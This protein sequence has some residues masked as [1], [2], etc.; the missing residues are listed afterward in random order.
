[1]QSKSQRIVANRCIRISV[2]LALA[3]VVPL[4]SQAAAAEPEELSLP[5][6]LEKALA[7]NKQLAAFEYRLA[8][9]AGRQQQ[10]GLLPNPRLDL[11]VENFAG[12]GDFSGVD[13]AETTLSL[14]WAVEPGLRS[15]RAGIEEARSARVDLDAH[16]LQ[17]DVAAETAQRF[18]SSLESQAHLRATEQALVLAEQT[19]EVVER[20]VRAGRAPAAERLRALASLA[21][22]R[23]ARDDVTH[24]QSV[25]YHRLAAQWGETSPSFGS[26][27]GA[28]LDLPSVAP[29]AE[30]EARVES[31]PSLARLAS[32]QRVAA[33]Q[34]RL[35][36]AR[37]WPTATPSLGVR[38]LE[39]T[40]DWAMVAGVSVPLQ[41]F[42]RNQGRVAE[43]R[44]R[45]ARTRADAESEL[46][47]VRTRLYA[48][49][50][51]MQHS[52]HR[53]EVL[54]DEVI[55]RIEATLDE[56]E[57]G[58]ERGRYPYSDLRAVQ[59][60]LRVAR[61]SLVEASTAAHRLVITLERLTGER[62]AK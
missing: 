49:Y 35:A 8:E 4:C 39:I 57:K 1:M 24:E 36:E 38:R 60:E 62:V 22:E 37:R 28:L 13:G 56:L 2:T 7:H 55:P 53:T 25:A 41:L 43:S 14:G 50:Q 33:A 48:I 10:A 19:V 18:L 45:L 58:Y 15:R 54:Q 11:I 46:V 5:R 52:V 21:M 34:L 12:Q 31:N 59:A 42:D 47:L 51:E 23:L 29:F 32:E 30:L 9:Q 3:S 61:R 26:V 20:R 44:A 16:I 6:A 40:G 27:Q 17:L